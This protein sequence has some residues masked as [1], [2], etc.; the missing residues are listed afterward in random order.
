ML[1]LDPLETVG[2]L[3][4]ERPN[5]AR[6][7]EAL[8]IDFCCGGKL[9][10]KQ[11][12]EKRGLDPLNVL[13]AIEADDAV[14]QKAELIDADAMTL[15][16]LADHIEAT[17]H[18]Y[19]KSELPRLDMMTEKVAR[20]HG[21]KDER[22]AVV[23]KAFV[24]LRAE[25]EPHMMKEEQILFPMIRRLEAANGRPEFHCGRI[26][27]PIRQMEHEHDQSGNALAVI[28][29]ATDNFDPP[30]W[31]CNTYRAMLDSLAR[32]EVDLHQHIH[33]ENNVL[34]P[35]AIALE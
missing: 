24:K 26:A 33:K 14:S 34:F 16:E 32:L 25:L 27:N 20:V 9:S 2:N 23:R 29:E 19:M 1:T 17:H 28:R 4:R 8:H 35:K 12:C 6:V 22:L 31:A 30:E 7:F 18:A 15:T 5:R 11:A 13:K 10:L 3:V 21:D